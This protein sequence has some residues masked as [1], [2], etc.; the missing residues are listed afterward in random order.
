M[1]HDIRGIPPA[2]RHVRWRKVLGYR[3]PLAA[4]TFLL[5]V[6]GGVLTWMLFLAHG[7]KAQDDWALDE[8]PTIHA[9]GRVLAVTPDSGFLC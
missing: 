1:V 2:P 6:Y 5:A 7:G 8:R 9:Q 3:W 4:A